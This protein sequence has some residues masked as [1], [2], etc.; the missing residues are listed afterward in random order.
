MHVK[1]LLAAI[2]LTILP[3]ALN[4]ESSRAGTA[5]LETLSATSNLGQLL[6]KTPKQN[7][8]PVRTK[9][10][11]KPTSPKPP[12]PTGEA[13]PIGEKEVMVVEIVVQGSREK[14]APELE[15]KV[16]QA[17]STKAGATTTR[18]KLEKDL[19][20]IQTI[21]AFAEVNIVPTDTAKGV[22]LT[23]V[24]TPYGLFKQVQLKTLPDNS[25]SV[26][27]QAE[28]DAIFRSQY[29]KPLNQ[30]DVREAAKKVEKLYQDRGYSL[31]RIFDVE[32]L[33][34][35]GTL[36]L[37]AA[38]GQIEKVELRFLSK[39]GSPVD[40]NQKPITGTT[41][42]YIVTREAKLKPGQVFNRDTVQQ[43][44]RRIY[45]LGLFD[46]VRVSLAPGSDPAKVVLQ[47]NAIERKTSNIIAGGG[48]SS[49]NGLFGSISYNQQNLGGN[50]QRLGADVQLGSRDF[51]FDVNYTDPWVGSDPSRLSY[52]INAFQRRSLSLVFDGGRTPVFLPNSDPTIR[53]V[54][55]ILRQG[56][57]VTFSRPLSGDP[58]ADNDWRASAG[59]QYQKVS[60]RNADGG[61]IA[62]VDSAGRNLSFSG[63]GED[64][65]LTVNLGLSRDLRNNPFDPTD[66][67]LWRFN[68][69]R[70][71]PIGRAN[72]SMTR[73]QGS[74]THY[75]PVK[76]LNFSQG[77]QALLFNV[78]GGTILGDVPPYE[79]F[80]LGGST[81]VRGYEE[82]DVGSGSSYVRASA[83][84]RFPIVSIIGG[85]LFLDYG[86]DLGTASSVPGN[87]AG[88]RGKPGN[89]LGYGAGVRIQSPL[90]SIR[91]DYGINS[92]GEGR[93]QFGIGEQF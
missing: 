34:P 6:A 76:L 74:Y 9:Q 61:A 42:E 20:A 22:K 13:A 49:A 45:G 84:Y 85:G 11:S 37:I 60:V 32:Q 70:S 69:D 19:R 8:S 90:G 53:E 39:D 30:N 75:F 89:G 91:I 48:V 88:V 43:D 15:Q 63:T 92:L 47:F 1:L 71:I 18:S 78:R 16:K 73:V 51:L 27:K 28:V 26:L 35:D 93:V 24:V 82:G 4:A 59:L 56:G 23:I 54:P 14:L 50:N 55:R 79:A 68:L 3:L 80:S 7:R 87:P 44:L 66:G 81:S 17:I 58:F 33:T 46:D 65:L 12:A 38:E 5:G 57:G 41:R 64:D 21:G 77:S 29:G 31:A 83:E 2:G 72:I 36:V 62:P 67:S 40:E 10:Q 52:N 86:S 25:T